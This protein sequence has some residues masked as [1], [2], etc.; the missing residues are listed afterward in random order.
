MSSAIN[1]GL[2]AVTLSGTLSARV[3]DAAR[4][5]T[6]PL[7]VLGG[8]VETALLGGYVATSGQ[9]VKPLLGWREG[10]ELAGAAALMGRR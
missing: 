9:T 3:C 4:Q 8:V 2:A 5:A 1:T 10:L 6:A 7:A